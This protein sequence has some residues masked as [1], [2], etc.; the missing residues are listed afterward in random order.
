MLSRSGLTIA[1][2]TDRRSQSLTQWGIAYQAATGRNLP[3]LVVQY[4]ADEGLA[5]YAEHM[6]QTTHAKHLLFDMGASAT[7]AQYRQALRVSPDLIMPIGIHAIETITINAALAAAADIARESNNEIAA[8]LVWCN[9]DHNDAQ[10]LAEAYETAAQ[11]D[12]DWPVLESYVPNLKRYRKG[13][14]TCPA[15]TGAYENVVREAISG[16]VMPLAA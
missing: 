10:E 8:H 9:V 12:N 14:G 4:T 13:L 6:R 7:D 16:E 3:F 5:D 1:F 15:H 11:P 2:D